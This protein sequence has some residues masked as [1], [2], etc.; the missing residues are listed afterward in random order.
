M[1]LVAPLPA[2]NAQPIF[3]VFALIWRLAWRSSSQV[4]GNFVIPACLRR[5][6]L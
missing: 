5:S 4:S 1:E 6:L 2:G 3:P